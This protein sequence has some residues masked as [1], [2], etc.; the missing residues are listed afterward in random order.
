MRPSA[1]RTGLSVRRMNSAF[2]DGGAGES[3]PSASGGRSRGR[4]R[5]Q[6]ASESAASRK[7][8][9]T[10]A[11]RQASRGVVRAID[12][13]RRSSGRRAISQEGGAVVAAIDSSAPFRWIRFGG[14]RSR[15]G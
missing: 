13:A 8:G 15:N 2:F 14:M 12:A 10:A 6:T 7:A 1:R 9:E 3:S 11:A 4:K 5:A